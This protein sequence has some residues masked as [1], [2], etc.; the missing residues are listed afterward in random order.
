MGVVTMGQLVI[1]S[2]SQY[3]LVPCHCPP[4]A[5]AGGGEALPMTS[6]GRSQAGGA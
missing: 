2:F 3:N 5:V 6:W 4:V 1:Q